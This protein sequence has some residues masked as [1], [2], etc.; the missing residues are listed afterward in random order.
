VQFPIQA[1]SYFLVHELPLARPWYKVSFPPFLFFFFFFFFKGLTKR[2][3]QNISDVGVQFQKMLMDMLTTDLECGDLLCL[4][5]S[6]SPS[7]SSLD[8]SSSSSIGSSLETSSVSA[9]DAKA[10]L[11]S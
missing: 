10:S 9:D 7:P 6:S 1:T 8:D 3:Q 4:R 2:I 11:E 5:R